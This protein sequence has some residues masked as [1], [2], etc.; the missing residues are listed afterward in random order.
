MDPGDKQT[1]KGGTG[2]NR[3]WCI[4]LGNEAEGVT[5]QI[6]LRRNILDMY[7]RIINRYPLERWVVLVSGYLACD[8]HL[9]IHIQRSI[10]S[11]SV[12]AQKEAR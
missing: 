7:L 3:A 2:R 1:R 10:N 8:L 6:H 4:L 9:G 5:F 11:P 12:S